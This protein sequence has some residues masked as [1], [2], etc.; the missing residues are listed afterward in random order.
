MHGGMNMG[1]EAALHGRT[2]AAMHMGGMGIHK[3]M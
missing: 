3:Y 2:G 1:V